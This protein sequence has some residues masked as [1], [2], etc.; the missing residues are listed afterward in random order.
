MS[1]PGRTIPYF[2]RS[3]R[4]R[5]I[6]RLVEEQVVGADD[7]WSGEGWARLDDSGGWLHLLADEDETQTWQTWPNYAVVCIE[8]LNTDEG[9]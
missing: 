8:W 5:V 1:V 2:K 6:L 9:D 3:Q 4:A 7:R